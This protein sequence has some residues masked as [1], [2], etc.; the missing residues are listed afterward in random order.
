[1]P[2]LT[3]HAP[4]RADLDA[5][6]TCGLCLPVCPTFRLTGDES[7]SP[8]GRIA[9]ISAVDRGVID[10]DE[11]FEAVTSFC[12]QCRACET[13]CPSMVPYG[14]IIEGA[15]SEVAVQLPSA[16]PR[17]RRLAV[18]RILRW[19]AV[20]RIV[21]GIAALVQRAGILRV[22]PVLGPQARGL[23]RLPVR[24]GTVR[25]GSWG[26]ASGPEVVLFAG[27][28]ADAWFPDIHRA[29][30]ELLVAAGFHVTAPDAQ[31]CC[32]ALAAHS[33]LADAADAMALI[34][35]DA[36]SGT[37]PIAVD[38]AGCGAHLK[39]YRR[40]PDGIAERA[41]DITELI[42]DAIDDGRLPLLPPTAEP[43][44]VMDPCH[45]EHGQRITTEPR[46]IVE[47]A[48]HTVVDV[49]PGGLCC[50]AAGLY[51]LDHP[52]TG[53]TLGERKADAV[54]VTG[55]RIVAAG[56][57][58]CEIQLRRFLGSGYQV[59]HPVEIYAAALAFARH[60]DPARS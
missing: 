59:R 10:V 1:M 14:D 29:S 2:W 35:T 40:G 48:G 15:R 53:R 5:C 31:T 6:V 17:T 50:G 28:V 55:A 30:I 26:D 11:R 27:C 13:A 45:L 51:Q 46:R 24:P 58:G 18:G 8:R 4:E 41:R 47:A 54:V 37:A 21:T 3:D 42:A 52:E 38:V 25:G 12:L 22:L 34:N 32:G 60:T 57:A 23:R 43:V 7:A 49:D 56:N 20:L 16:V 44:A 39:G 9:A 36:L 33:G 19:S